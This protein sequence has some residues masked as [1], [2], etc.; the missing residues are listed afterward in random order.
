VFRILVSVRESLIL[1]TD[2]YE[3]SFAG[4]IAARALISGCTLGVFDALA[5]RPDRPEGLAERLE[6]DALGMETLLTALRS[7]GWVEEREDGML[8][9]TEVAGRTLVSGSPESVAR[10]IGAQNA[11]HW[12]T[13]GRLDEVMRT[14]RPAGWHEAG[15]DDPLWEAYIRGLYEVSRAEH[16][17]NAALVQVPD[18]REM[19]DVAGGHGAFAMAMCRRHPDLHATVLDL[20]ASAAVGR[21]IV[22]EAGYADRVDFR[23][24]DALEADLGEDLDVVSVFNLVHHLSAEENV[25]LLGRAQ[26]A[27]RPGGCVVVGETERPEPGA[28]VH[29]MGALSGLLFYAI[30]RARTYTV[31]EMTAWLEGEVEVHRNPHSPWRVV[32]VA[33]KAAA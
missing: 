25:R 5:E 10:F 20:P 27:L 7:L 8:A 26:A 18:P 17:G 23:E 21:R 15:P 16:D 22:G 3:Q 12:D 31:A 2:P 6:L 32:I 19:V 14:G 4:M 1:G 24:G 30:S 11:Y 13:L 28:P 9:P 29:Q 33:R